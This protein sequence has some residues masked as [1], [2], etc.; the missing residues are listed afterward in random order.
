MP[1]LPDSKVTSV[2]VSSEYPDL[3][4]A[5]NKL[6]ISTFLI[7]RNLNLEESIC[8]HPDCVI[9]H[10]NQ[11]LLVD[12]SISES[13]VNLLTSKSV[14]K[15][16]RIISIGEMAHSPYP[17]DIRLNCKRINNKIICN[18]KYISENLRRLALEYDFELIHVNQGYAAC[19]TV[20]V[21]DSAIITDDESIHNSVIKY[22]IDS[23]LISKGSVQL[24]N[25]NYG[26]IGGA[27]GMIDRNLL[28]FYGNIEQHKD[29]N[30]IIKFLNKYDTQYLNLIN[31]PLTDV[32]GIIPITQKI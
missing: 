29:A 5:L 19:S 11:N 6:G 14:V 2:A 20:V 4:V 28:G 15:N 24:K 16:Y 23:L 26:F 30:E 21:N 22:G 12:S 31:G 10:L 13:I 1:G 27:C 9:F 18:T 32:G 7:E 17:Y 3:I 8:S 25:H